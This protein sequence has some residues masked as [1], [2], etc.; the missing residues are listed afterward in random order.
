[1]FRR[2]PGL[3]GGVLLLATTVAAN[4]D[5]SSEVLRVYG[6]GGPHRVLEECAELFSER[7]GV[8]VVVSKA[9]PH[10][11]DEKVRA[12]GDIYYGGAQCMLEEFDQRNPGVLD[13]G[14]VEQLHPREVGIIV[15]K[16]NPLAIQGLECLTKDGVGLL[17]VKLENMRHLHGAFAEN[18]QNLKS[19]VYTGRQGL[20]VWRENRD[21]DA[22]IT[23]KSWY[24]KL[25]QDAEFIEIP[26][27]YALR[28][29]PLVLTRHTQQQREAMNFIEFLKSEEAYQIFQKHGWD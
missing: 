27:E 10:D 2:L 23:Y 9:L 21:V 3:V 5:S 7:H 28:A 12:D 17:D 25:D 26:D 22:W 4:V 1:M 16:G 8:D 13:M 15:R 14:S 18:P 29:T 11:L 24:I 6:P 19:L 20:S